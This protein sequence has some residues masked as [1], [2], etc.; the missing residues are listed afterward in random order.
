MRNGFCVLLAV[1]L[2]LGGA[3]PALADGAVPV[4]LRGWSAAEGYQYVCFGRYEQR[5]SDDEPIL[6]RVLTVEDGQALLLSEMILD[7]RPLG[8]ETEAQRKARFA[9]ALENGKMTQEEIDAWKGEAPAWEDSGMRDWLNDDFAWTAFTKAERGALTAAGK[10]GNVFLLSRAELCDPAFG[11]TADQAEK[12]PARVAA[13]TRF[14][15][16]QGLY[17]QN[18]QES[19]Y[20]TRTKDGPTTYMQVR[21]TGALGS[22]RYDRDNVGVRPAI[23]VDIE[24]AGLS[25]GAGT[26]DDPFRGEDAG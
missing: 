9:R 20:Y 8:D 10:L 5:R 7:V 15:Q 2:L 19:S 1:A 26:P 12:D 6:W 24:A 3:C 4:A 23:W 17:V 14:A 18:S 13:G 22:A 21:S 25:A 11:F 16:D